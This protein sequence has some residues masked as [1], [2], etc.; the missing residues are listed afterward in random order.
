MGWFHLAVVVL[1]AV[2]TVV[3]A[4]QNFQLVTIA[5]LRHSA[6]IPLAIL[7]AVIYLLGTVT[8]G[9]L[10]AL[11]RHSLERAKRFTVRT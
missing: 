2:A 5:F 11:L 10:F 6:T 1:L 4:A 7:V 8:G 9:S 3:F